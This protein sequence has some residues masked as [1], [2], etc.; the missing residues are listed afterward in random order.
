MR[1]L[2]LV[3][4]FTASF[5]QEL[6]VEGNLKVQGNIDASNQRVTNVGNPTDL[7]DA[8][9]TEFLQDAL[10]DDGPF[11]YKLVATRLTSEMLQN[12]GSFTLSY[13]N[14]GETS[15]VSDFESYL[16]TLEDSGWNIYK[17]L[18]YT[19]DSSYQM[20]YNYYIFRR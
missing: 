9:N 18:P 2:I 3:L 19:Y 10:R 8:V 16:N 4:M 13:K 15:W 14:Y 7:T 1:Y 11:E 20:S 5:S 6:E 17:T 12:N